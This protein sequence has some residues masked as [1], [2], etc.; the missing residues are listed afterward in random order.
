VIEEDFRG[1]GL[2][3]VAGGT[4]PLE[5]TRVN[6]V[7]AVTR[8]T[9]CERVLLARGRAMATHAVDLQMSAAQ[10]EATVLVVIEGG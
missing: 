6:I 7:S 10:R 4:R 9:V 2:L 8:T 1:P 3:V 5:L